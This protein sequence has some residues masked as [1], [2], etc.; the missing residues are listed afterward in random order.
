V[1]QIDARDIVGGGGGIHC[2]TLD[3]PKAG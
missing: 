2:I 1:V 3:Q